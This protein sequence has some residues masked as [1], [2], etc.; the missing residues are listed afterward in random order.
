[1]SLVS[2]TDTSIFDHPVGLRYTIKQLFVSFF[3][4]NNQPDKLISYSLLNTPQYIE[5]RSI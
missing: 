5:R 1:M 4:S 3:L 2:G